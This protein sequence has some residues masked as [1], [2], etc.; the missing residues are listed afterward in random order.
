MEKKV[1]VNEDNL[2][3]L[4]IL[5]DELDK[6]NDITYKET[7]IEIEFLIKEEISLISKL[8]KPDN[9]LKHYESI[10]AGILTLISSTHG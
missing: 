1:I 7:L 6:S 2:T 5:V 9:K 10:C 4:R 8:K 3:K